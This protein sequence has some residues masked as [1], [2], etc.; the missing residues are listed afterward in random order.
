[1]PHFPH[2]DK[3]TFQKKTSTSTALPATQKQTQNVRG[4]VCEA[5]QSGDRYWNFRVTINYNICTWR[6]L[7]RYWTYVYLWSKLCRNSPSP[8]IVSGSILFI[9]C[10]KIPLFSEGTN[11]AKRSSKGDHKKI[12]WHWGMVISQSLIWRGVAQPKSFLP[13]SMAQYHG[14]NR[15]VG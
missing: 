9:V 10:E 5:S 11:R 3:R 6:F 12:N 13:P 1:M 14:H 7:S 15:T 8:Q 4:K 2:L